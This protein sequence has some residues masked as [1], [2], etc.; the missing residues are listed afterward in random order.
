MWDI[1]RTLMLLHTMKKYTLLVFYVYVCFLNEFDHLRS[2]CVCVCVCEY[3][4][5]CVYNYARAI[6]VNAAVVQLCYRCV[7]ISK[8]KYPGKKAQEGKGFGGEGEEE[9]D[10]VTFNHTF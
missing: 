6:I 9:K 10:P 8:L 4:S 1:R 3:V 2:Y 5:M 7:Y